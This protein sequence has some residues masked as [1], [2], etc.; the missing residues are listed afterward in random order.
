MFL[1][2]RPKFVETESPAGNRKLPLYVRA[3]M[4]PCPAQTLCDFVNRIRPET[5]SVGDCEEAITFCQNGALEPAAYE[6][7]IDDTRVTITSGD[8]EGAFNGVSTLVQLLDREGYVPFVRISDGPSCSYRSVM[9]DL[10][11]VWHDFDL[12]LQYIDLCRFYKIKVL[13]LHFTDYQSY[14]L[15]SRLF[16]KLS[17]P[18][19]SYSPEQI[20]RLCDYAK[21]RGVELVPEIDVPGHCVA[22]QQHYPDTFGTDGIIRFSERA[23]DSMKQLFGELCDMF[24]DSKYIH[25]GGDEAEIGR[26]LDHHENF[27]FY[28]S[29]G[30]EPEGQDTAYVKE[31]LYAAFVNEMANAVFEKGKQPIAWE[32]FKEC[33]NEFVRKDLIM[34][35]WENYYQT[36]PSLLKAGFQ[37]INCSWQPLYVVT[38]RSFWSE[39][40]VFDWDVT[41]WIPVHDQS[42]YCGSFVKV[43]DTPQIMGAGLCVWSDRIEQFYGDQIREGVKDE[44]ELV[45]GRL[46][47]LSENA[48]NRTKVRSFD[49]YLYA[50]VRDKWKVETILK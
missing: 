36:A 45:K 29:L 8:E 31:R 1:I 2:P 26:W 30:I 49:E 15:P 21:L 27:D 4:Y 33:V 41:T 16:P 14:T 7:I 6:I 39:R 35:S 10:A 12:I 42:P 5:L 22:F 11:R 13:H 20:R 47:A 25:I 48:W 18:G 43:E 50:R 38:P 37:V 44:F 9:L 40:E 24:P 32:G 3:N 34:V 19:R 23:I 17:T 28:R 46:P